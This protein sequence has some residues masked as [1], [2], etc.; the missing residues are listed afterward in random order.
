MISNVVP[1]RLISSCFTKSC[2][3]GPWLSL[4]VVVFEKINLFS[5]LRVLVQSILHL[6][7]PTHKQWLEV[8]QCSIR[9]R[10]R[11]HSPLASV[12]GIVSS[13]QMIDTVEV[14]AIEWSVLVVAGLAVLAVSVDVL[15]R[16]SSSTRHDRS[17]VSVRLAA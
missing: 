5:A 2:G 14:L 7:D 3:I 13:N 6:G 8:F 16:L 12:V 1:E 15:P 11:H 17:K 4:T 10:M 9:E